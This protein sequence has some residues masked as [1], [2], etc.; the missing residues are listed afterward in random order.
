MFFKSN[1]EIEII[2]L[3]GDLSGLTNDE[4]VA[5]AQMAAGK[6]NPLYRGSKKVAKAAAVL[7][8]HVAKTAWNSAL[9][10]LL[11]AQKARTVGAVWKEM[12]G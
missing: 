4:L 3:D 1:R 8:K 7:S 5:A 11:G 9:E 2:D 6:P 12:W 10:S